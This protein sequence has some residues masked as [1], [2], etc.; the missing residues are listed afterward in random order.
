MMVAPCGW[1]SA[2]GKSEVANL[3]WS[4]IWWTLMRRQIKWIAMPPSGYLTPLCLLHNGLLLQE[5][6]IYVYLH[7]TW[8]YLTQE[9]FQRNGPCALGLW[10]IW[11]LQGFQKSRMK[12][13]VVDCLSHWHSLIIGRVADHWF[14]YGIS[15][16]AATSLCPG[17]RW[18]TFLETKTLREIAL[19]ANAASAAGLFPE[20]GKITSHEPSCKWLA[21]HDVITQQ[22]LTRLSLWPPKFHVG[23]ICLPKNFL[24]CDRSSW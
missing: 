18:Q 11:L 24:S 21:V 5:Q 19:L 8:P 23:Q 17:T 9:Q 2:L 15:K 20:N 10:L 1:H 3:R 14:I 7:A 13:R 22:R 6:Y 4:I 16:L 12:S